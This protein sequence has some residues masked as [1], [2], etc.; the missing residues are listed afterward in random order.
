[1]Q[2]IS[3]LMSE[4]AAWVTFMQPPAAQP[5]VYDIAEVYKNVLPWT[6]ASAAQVR[7]HALGCWAQLAVLVTS[8]VAEL[9]LPT[10]FHAAQD[11]MPRVP[12]GLVPNAS[13]PVHPSGQGLTADHLRFKL[14]SV[15]QE[16]LRTEEELQYLP[17]DAANALGYFQQQRTILGSA[18]GK[19][20]A[21]LGEAST[22]W[23]EQYMR[24]RQYILS[25]WQ[26]QIGRLHK[27]AW[28]AFVKVGWVAV[29]EL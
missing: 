15:Q 7:G 14:Y 13:C 22:P 25:S 28:A 4:W 24:G 21:A 27:E 12:Q 23:E 29:P 6:E 19:C 11:F 8:F 5:P 16:L 10:L 18:Q 2:L 26:A 3:Q 20:A 9:S 17:Q 1:M